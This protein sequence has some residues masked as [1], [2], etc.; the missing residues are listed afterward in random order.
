MSLP[1][2]F[3]ME[4]E[5]IVKEEEKKAFFLI[6]DNNESLLRIHRLFFHKLCYEGDINI[7]RDDQYFKR[8]HS[9]ALIL[10]KESA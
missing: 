2:W 7:S 8:S 10:N 6:S 9:F 5:E 4:K 1:G 3:S